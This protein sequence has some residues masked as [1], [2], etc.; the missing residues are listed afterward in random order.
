MVEQAAY[1]GMGLSIHVA[2][3]AAEDDFVR[4]GEGRF[5]AWHRGSGIPVE[6]RGVGPYRYLADRGWLDA[7]PHVLLVHGVK[8]GPEDLVDLGAR[9]AVHLVHCPRSNARLGVGLAPVRAALDV[10][11][12]L[13][14]GTDGA[15]SADRL[16]PFE[17]MR[18]GLS[19]A[20]ARARAEDPC[21]LSGAEVLAAAFRRAPALGFGPGRLEPGAPADLCALS[22][23]GSAAIPWPEDASGVVLQAAACDVVFTM[24]EGEILYQ[25]GAHTRVGAE[26]IRAAA[27]DL[28]PGRSG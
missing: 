24:V 19:L 23:E 6:A 7:T 8:L 11:V 9:Q 25:E 14:L 28:S 22:L 4:R 3:T 10:G 20:R 2:E 26:A 5:A 21:A 15:C 1:R 27:R 18:T 12:S 13:L 17:E 16:D